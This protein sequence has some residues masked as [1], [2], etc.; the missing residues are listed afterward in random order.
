MRVLIVTTWYP[1][2]LNPVSGTFVR[3]DA[4]L[5][6]RDH[7]VEVA[8]LI[9][10]HLLSEGDVA[11]DRD[12][13]IPIARI[14]MSTSDPLA[15]RR[16]W[17]SLGPL[18]EGRDLIHTQ[19]FSSLLAFTGR[20]IDV[21]WVHS[22]HWS[23]VADPT[24]LMPAE[25]AALRLTGALLRRPDVVTAVSGY[26][27]DR[28]RRYR[29]DG[30]IEIVP[31]LVA[32][33]EPVP[34]PRDPDHL[35]LVSVGGLVAG[36]RPALAIETARELRRRGRSTSLTWVGD[37]PLR[38]TLSAGLEADD[39][40]TL[41]GAQDAAGVARELDAADVF[42]LPTVGETLCLSALEAIAHGRPVV[43]GDRGGQREYVTPA[44]GALVE[45]DLPSSFADAVESVLQTTTGA[46]PADIAA[47]I[48]GRFDEQAIRSGLAH[49]YARAQGKRAERD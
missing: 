8:H 36:K 47:T 27:A 10:P 40:V 31:S 23:G 9:S 14:P 12:S 48:R 43:L 2:I 42:L 18:I 25:R 34:A 45:G 3:R 49:A 44:N 32:H 15:I 11:L 26:L 33:V 22:E 7:D 30:D 24:T 16:A 13:P 35:R 28:I 29:P 17:R 19:A 37:G 39:V 46:S 4:E 20:R 5:I 1:S 38:A 41:V 21:P 6:A